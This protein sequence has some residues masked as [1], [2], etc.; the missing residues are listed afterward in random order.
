[1]SSKRY[2]VVDESDFP[3]DSDR[4]IVE[5]EGVEVAVFKIDGEYHALANFCPHQSGPLCEGKTLGKLRGAK[6]GWQFQYDDDVDVVAC[7]W[8]GWRFDIATG[9]SVETDKYKVPRYD[10]E[11]ENG[12]IL[13]NR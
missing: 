10:V 9:E 12:K 8:H 13:V 4:I 1:M 6:D 11:V 3:E 2:E 5:I 7:P